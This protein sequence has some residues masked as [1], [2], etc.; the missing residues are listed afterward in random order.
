MDEIFDWGEEKEATVNGTWIIEGIE[1]LDEWEEIGKI[2][3]EISR[4]WC[5]SIE[6]EEIAVCWRERP[7]Q[8]IA[9]VD[10]GGQ[11]GGDKGG[12][13]LTEMGK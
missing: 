8:G 13:K 9:R 7:V 6:N 1:E 4:G 3:W 11:D 12:E 2:E 5:W 10:T